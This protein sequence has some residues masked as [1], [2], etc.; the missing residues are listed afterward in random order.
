[1]C[2]AGE[3]VSSLR[4]LGI[5]LLTVTRGEETQEGPEIILVG[6]RKGQ[7]FRPNSPIADCGVLFSNQQRAT[8][9]CAI[10]S[11]SLGDCARGVGK[12][13]VRVSIYVGTFRNTHMG[14]TGRYGVLHTCH[15][16]QKNG[17]PFCSYLMLHFGG[18]SDSF[19]LS[20]RCYSLIFSFLSPS[21][22]L[23]TP[24][25]SRPK[26]RPHPI[27]TV[28]H[29]TSRFRFQSCC[30]PAI[31]LSPFHSTHAWTKVRIALAPVHVAAAEMA[32]LP[33]LESH[34]L[35]GSS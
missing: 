32:A 25:A 21:S 3:I 29:Y 24:N 20:F 34:P 31:D 11:G 23:K 4:L 18:A 8:G 6:S 7:T 16:M 26:L 1:M 30:P 5:T 9:Q 14:Y 17:R 13:G 33:S 28:I 27:F 19:L 12:S 10:E 15:V 35:D 22:F 2:D